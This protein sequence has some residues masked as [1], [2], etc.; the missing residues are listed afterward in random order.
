MKSDLDSLDG[1]GMCNFKKEG[2][3]IHP[4][5][6]NANMSDETYLRQLQAYYDWSGE[7]GTLSRPELKS[8]LLIRK[9]SV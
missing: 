7:I 8:R 6:T 4:D 9:P 2:C 3:A 1:F 5:D